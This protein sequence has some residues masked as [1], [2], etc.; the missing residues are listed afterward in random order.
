M[1][2]KTINEKRN[3]KFYKLLGQNHE[4]I[5]N[6]ILRGK[7]I[8]YECPKEYQLNTKKPL[9]LDWLMEYGK[10][11]EICQ[12]RSFG[13]VKLLCIYNALMTWISQNPDEEEKWV[14]K[15]EWQDFFRNNPKAFRKPSLQESSKK[16]EPK[17]I[18]VVMPNFNF[19]TKKQGIAISM[20]QSDVLITMIDKKRKNGINK[21]IVFHFRNDSFEKFES[22]YLVFAKH[23]NRIYFK[24]SDAR[25]GFKLTNKHKSSCS[26]S[27]TIKPKDVF[28]FELF[29]K[30]ELD[31]KFDE[32]Y[33]MYYVENE[34]D[35]EN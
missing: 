22:D 3:L 21:T 12:V 14:Y 19:Y 27:A 11:D 17:P 33:K 28:G 20:G 5:V 32:I 31:L 16:E 24:K 35:D 25:S 6:G 2:E 30:K 13:P 10:P 26:F 9:I 29:C 18:P 23:E 1:K 34:E 15:K 7:D 8:Y 4:V